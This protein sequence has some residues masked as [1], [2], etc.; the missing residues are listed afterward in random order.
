MTLLPKFKSEPSLL[1]SIYSLLYNLVSLG[2]CHMSMIPTPQNL[3]WIPVPSKKY[4]VSLDVTFVENQPYYQHTLQGEN[5]DDEE[6]VVGGSMGWQEI[7]GTLSVTTLQGGSS[8]NGWEAN[9][10]GESPIRENGD[11]RELEDARGQGELGVK[12][13][14]QEISQ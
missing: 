8:H 12:P 7:L 3:S 1:P 4:L 6:Y 5:L 2:V 13:P 14:V 10:Q 11:Q 9:G